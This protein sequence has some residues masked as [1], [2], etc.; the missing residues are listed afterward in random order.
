MES[1]RTLACARFLPIIQMLVSRSR[2][3]QRPHRL[4]VSPKLACI[5]AVVH[6]T[7]RDCSRSKGGS[8]ALQ[9]SDAGEGGR[10]VKRITPE[11]D[12]GGMSGSQAKKS[13]CPALVLGGVFGYERWSLSL[14]SISHFSQRMWYMLAARNSKRVAINSRQ[15]LRM[16]DVYY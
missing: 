2:F 4:I 7:A 12:G 1:V 3:S 11:R 13:C 6:S 15:P 16:H 9:R 10:R 8:S 5:F 14:P